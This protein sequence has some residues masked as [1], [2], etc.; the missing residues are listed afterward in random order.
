MAPEQPGPSLAD[1]ISLEQITGEIWSQKAIEIGVTN[2]AYSVAIGL[3]V[4]GAVLDGANDGGAAGGGCRLDGLGGGGVTG[5]GKDGGRKPE[6][7]EGGKGEGDR[8]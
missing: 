7:S 3:N 1:G 6:G 2:V 5:S 4:G 8:S